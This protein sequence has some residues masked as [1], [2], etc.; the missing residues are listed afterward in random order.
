MGAPTGGQAPSLQS[1]IKSCWTG[2]PLFCRFILIT[3]TLLMLVS[4]F[5]PSIFVVLACIPA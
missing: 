1:Q 4:F 2:I 5:V 3:T